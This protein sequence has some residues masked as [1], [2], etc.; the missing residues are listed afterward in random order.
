[1]SRPMRL[2][3]QNW[4]ITTLLI[5][6][7]KHCPPLTKDIKCDV[8]IVG[9]GFSG[10][11]AAAQFLKKGLKVVLIDKNIVGGSSSGRS[12]GFLTPDSELE[13]HQLVRRY[14][15]KAA[16]E[17]WEAPLR[18]I[19]RIVDAIETYDIECGLLKQDSLFLGLGAGG[20]ERRC[21]GARVPRER[22]IHRSAHLR[23][24]AVAGRSRCARVHRR[25]TVWRHLRNQ[26]AALL[27]GIE[28]SADRQRHADL[29]E[30]R[31]GETR[32]PHSLHARRQRDGGPHHHRGRQAHRTP[33]ARSR[34]KSSTHR[35]SSA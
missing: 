23:R 14:G 27:T 10:V 25:H 22:R 5:A 32:G 21:G 31:D 34:M 18:G 16:G 19:D 35:R 4:W 11:A 1:M 7:Y 2:V 17:I 28:G 29:R 6:A 12:A 3:N 24:R 33:S 13:L 9:G 26:P 30:H 15:A 20:Q 8:L